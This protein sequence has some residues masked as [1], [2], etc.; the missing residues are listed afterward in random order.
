MN[1]IEKLVKDTTYLENDMSE[2]RM[3]E[4]INLLKERTA[5]LDRLFKTL[6]I[7][8]LEV[9]TVNIDILECLDKVRC[10]YTNLSMELESLE[11]EKRLDRLEAKDDG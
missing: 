11:I 3:E 9:R 2:K 1:D 5:Y 8:I 4:N 10:N 7:D 6:S